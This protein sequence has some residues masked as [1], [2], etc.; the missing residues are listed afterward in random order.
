MKCKPNPALPNPAASRPASGPAP[1]QERVWPG[2]KRSPRRIPGWILPTAAGSAPS[3]L[4]GKH[5]SHF[6]EL[7][8]PRPGAWRSVEPRTREAAS[9][10][11]EGE[12]GSPLQQKEGV[13]TPTLMSILSSSSPWQ[14]ASSG[15]GGWKQNPCSL[16]GVW[17][18]DTRGGF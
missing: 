1:G 17:L 5:F 16:R 6:V 3:T 11:R 10:P 7:R 8:E 12:G 2:V 14:P 18:P 13:H 9:L 4:L 15:E